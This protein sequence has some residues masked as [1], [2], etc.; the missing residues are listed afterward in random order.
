MTIILN[1][2][3]YCYIVIN[4]NHNN[5]SILECS[6]KFKTNRDILIEIVAIDRARMVIRL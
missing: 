4:D 3:L 2:L 6:E 1:V 5:A